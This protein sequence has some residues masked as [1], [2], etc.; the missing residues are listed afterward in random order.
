METATASHFWPLARAY[1]YD[2][3]GNDEI[4]FQVDGDGRV[5]GLWRWNRSMA[6]LL[7]PIAL[8]R[9]NRT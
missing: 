7:A 9:V 3:V 8:E 6:R 1:F 2:N 4:T 5:T